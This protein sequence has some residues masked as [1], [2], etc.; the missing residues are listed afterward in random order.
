MGP[1]DLPLHTPDRAAAGAPSWAPADACRLPS[2]A[3]PSRIAAFDA[4]FAS[5]RSVERPEP[6]RLRIAFA[7]D[8]GTAAR[9]AELAVR[10]ADCCGFFTFALTAAAG[11]LVL[12]V[13]VPPDRTAVLDGLAAQAAEVRS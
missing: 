10:E 3:V 9:I 1:L 6:V 4:L 13:A 2:A 7:S 11:S 12:E 5:A 8:P